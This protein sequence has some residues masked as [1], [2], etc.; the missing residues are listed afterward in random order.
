MSVCFII[1]TVSLPSFSSLT[2]WV[3]G[4]SLQDDDAYLG[5]PGIVA[6]KHVFTRPVW[7]ARTDWY[8]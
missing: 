2:A 1:F 3:V 4:I 6:E 8:A 7:E 5:A